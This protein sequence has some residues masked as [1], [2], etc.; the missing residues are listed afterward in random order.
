MEIQ[1]PSR[2]C[3][4]C[5]GPNARCTLCS[6]VKAKRGCTCCGAARYGSCSNSS[7]SVNNL[8]SSPP[9]YSLSP[10]SHASSQLLPQEDLLLIPP[11]LPLPVCP[12]QML[13]ST[14][15]VLPSLS[16]GLFQPPSQNS[17]AV[18][19]TQVHDQPSSQHSLLY[20][21]L[22]HP[23]S[24]SLNQAQQ[25]IPTMPDHLDQFAS[26]T[27][28]QPTSSAFNHHVAACRSPC[29]V[30]GVKRVS[31]P[32]CGTLTCN[33]TRMVSFLVRL[34]PLGLINR[35]SSLVLA[36]TN[37]YLLLDLCLTKDGAVVISPHSFRALPPFFPRL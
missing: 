29:T 5:N 36:A 34:L 22:Q 33:S 12:E 6:C 13:S 15:Q 32:P 31:A 14:E 3:C 37:L 25:S 4:K 7:S 35:A 24:T 16:S 27:S 10:T 30:Q 8:W 11:Q 23:I 19:C 26:S 18:T 20:S 9:S 1:F 21:S 2:P 28:V 17:N